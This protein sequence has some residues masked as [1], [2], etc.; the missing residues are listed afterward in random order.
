MKFC[1]FSEPLGN[2]RHLLLPAV[3]TRSKPLRSSVINKCS[4]E[5]YFLR[6][7]YSSNS[8]YFVQSNTPQQAAGHD[9][10]SF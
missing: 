5:S 1:A 9:L 10:A 8:I 7:C 3:R 6:F 2:N 4:A